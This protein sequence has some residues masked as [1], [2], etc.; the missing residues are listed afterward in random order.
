M[1]KY[2]NVRNSLGPLTGV[3]R[4]TIELTKRMDNLEVLAPE[5]NI[6]PGHLWEQLILPQK[7][8]DGL[9][10]SPANTGPLLIE[11][12]VVTIHDMATIDHPE[13]FNKNFSRWYSFL[14]PRLAHRCRGIITVSEFSKSRIVR[15]CNIE[16]SK[17]WVT[18]LGVDRKFR[19]EEN[20]LSSDLVL[21]KFGLGQKKYYLFVSSLE[22]RKNITRILDAWNGWMDRPSDV[23]LAIV[24]GE[25]KVFKQV[26]EMKKTSD[27]KLLGR[28]TDEDL[29]TIYRNAYAFIYVSLYEGFGLPVLEAMAAGV[30]VISSN[31]TSLPEVAAET[32]LL[33][34]PTDTQAIL[35]NM[36]K[37]YFDPVLRNDM[38]N[39]GKHHSSTYSWDKTAKETQHILNELCL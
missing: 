19:S 13:W 28:V 38:A 22:P 17:V 39:L 30:P 23:E 6:L 35:N 34:D 3:Q 5:T 27:I 20:G 37:L 24:G 26:L 4:Y 2:V 8:K 16:P 21:S 33:V 31:S 18:P 14:L 7:C 9:L 29:I 12:Q 25:N 10:W 1:Q 15:L 11:K 36:K 32:A